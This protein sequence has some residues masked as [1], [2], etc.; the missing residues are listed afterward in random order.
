MFSEKKS[1]FENRDLHNCKKN[2]IFAGFFG[3]KKDRME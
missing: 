1:I 2:S 3:A